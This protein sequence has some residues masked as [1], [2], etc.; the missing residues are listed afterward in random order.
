ML[1]MI[2][3]CLNGTSP[4]Y[5]SSKFI[6][7]HSVHN[8]STRGQISN[9]LI[10]P[11]CNSNSG[12]RMFTSRS[13]QIWNNLPQDIRINYQTMSLNQFRNSSYTFT[14]KLHVI[15]CYLYCYVCT[16]SLYYVMVKLFCHLHVCILLHV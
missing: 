6:F 1:I 16:S 9:S 4:N 3:K 7:T 15:H 13:S 12:R 5:L 8:Y 2:F 11:Q 10:I 14:L